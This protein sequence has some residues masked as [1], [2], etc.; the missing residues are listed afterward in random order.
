M[1]I[2]VAAKVRCTLMTALAENAEQHHHERHQGDVRQ[3]M[4]LVHAKLAGTADN[5]AAERGWRPPFAPED[6]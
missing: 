4:L 1:A 2:K 5:Q 6:M 3:W